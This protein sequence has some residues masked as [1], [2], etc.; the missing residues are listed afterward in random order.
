MFLKKHYQG[1]V[2]NIMNI[3][4]SNFRGGYPWVRVRV[5]VFNATF[6]NI[7]VK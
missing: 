1:N 7:S 4:H 3:S 5:V 2:Q 6:N